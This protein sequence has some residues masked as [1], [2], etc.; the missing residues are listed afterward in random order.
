MRMEM[1]SE[2]TPAPDN[3]SQH[4]TAV[5]PVEHVRMLASYVHQVTARPTSSV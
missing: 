5:Q 4:S 2:V 3:G 1:L